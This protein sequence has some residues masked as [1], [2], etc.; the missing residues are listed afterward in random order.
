MSEEVPLEPSP[1]LTDAPPIPVTALPEPTAPTA[2]AVDTEPRP[3]PIWASVLVILL[4]LGGGGWIMHWYVTTDALSHETK[5]LPANAVTSATPPRAA[6]MAA[7]MAPAVAAPAIRKQDD[8]SWWVHSP[9]A[10]MLA[11]V[12]TKP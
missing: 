8:T 12:K 2:A 10:A 11:D 9:E 7:N 6:R 5:I 4:C 3:I 1:A